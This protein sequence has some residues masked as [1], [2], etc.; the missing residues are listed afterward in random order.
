VN[1]RPV[2]SQSV[3]ER[4]VAGA[5]RPGRWCPR[6]SGRAARMGTGRC[7]PR[8]RRRRHHRQQRDGM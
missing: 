7:G 8:H 6:R 4:P 2:L 5:R 1:E 3:E